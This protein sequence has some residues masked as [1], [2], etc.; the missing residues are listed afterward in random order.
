MTILN[1]Q[2]LI[3]TTAALEGY[4]NQFLNDLQPGETRVLDSLRIYNGATYDNPT[5]LRLTGILADVTFSGTDNELG[6]EAISETWLQAKTGG[7]AWTPIGGNPVDGSDYLEL[8][9]NAEY[10]TVELRVVV[11]AVISTTGIL[12]VSLTAW[13]NEET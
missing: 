11:P 10:Q 2:I 3:I 9:A 5:Y 4:P 6:A 12:S 8:L 1:C 13:Y 7:G